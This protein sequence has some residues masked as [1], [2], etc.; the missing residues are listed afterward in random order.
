MP[1]LANRILALA[2]GTSKGPFL[3]PQGQRGW[4]GQG[5][6]WGPSRAM[7]ACFTGRELPHASSPS[8]SRILG[9]VQKKLPLMALSTTMAESF[10]ELDTESSLG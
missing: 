10:K 1:C 7:V 2:E 6:M 9:S 8:L 4:V 5:K 3:R